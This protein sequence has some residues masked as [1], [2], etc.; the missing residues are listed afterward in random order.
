M[1]QNWVVERTVTPEGLGQTVRRVRRTRGWD[2]K[3]LAAL[4]QV[5][6]MTI[7]RLERGQDVSIATAL[8]ALS[9]CGYSMT[10]APKRARV[11]VD[12]IDD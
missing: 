5:S 3:R 8:R 7:S 11:R 1:D 4:C 2:Q 6:R 10:I 9:E 12:E